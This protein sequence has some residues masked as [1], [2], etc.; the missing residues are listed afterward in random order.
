MF[1][2]HGLPEFVR[3]E[4][5]HAPPSHDAAVRLLATAGIHAGIDF[6][7]IGHVVDPVHPQA[8]VL[9]IGPPGQE[10]RPGAVGEHPAQKVGIKGQ[11]GPLG[12]TAAVAVRGGKKFGSHKRRTEFAADGNGVI[13]HAHG[14]VHEG[15]FESDHPGYADAG[16]RDG[17]AGGQT[18]LAL[19]HQGMAGKQEVRA[20]GSAAQALDLPHAETGVRLQFPHSLGRQLGIGMGQFTGSA[21]Q[22]IVPAF[23]AV[24][25]QNYPPGAGGQ[26]VDPSQD[27]LDLVVGNG[28]IGHADRHIV[29]VHG[30]PVS[31]FY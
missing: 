22:G 13:G 28:R 12:R 10:S 8:D 19:D 25:F 17:L 20:G 4:A 24:G 9:R 31:P 18:Q 27:V 14:D 2:G 26:I 16:R 11:A 21:I 1:D 30:H 3:P 15:V 23:D 29:D 7:G 5:A 6:A